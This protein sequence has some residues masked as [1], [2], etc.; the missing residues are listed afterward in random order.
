MADWQDIPDNNLSTIDL[1]LNAEGASGRF[2]DLV[3]SVYQQESGSG[4]NSRTSNAG[5]VGGMQIKPDTF[6]SVADD[7]WDINHPVDNARAG[8]R[9][10]KTMWDKSGGNPQLA[11]AGYYGG[12]GGLDKARRGVAVSDP[13]NPNAPTTLEYGDQVAARM[14][15][16]LSSLADVPAKGKSQ[17][18]W[19][20]IP[21]EDI[22]ETPKKGMANILPSKEDVQ[23]QADYLRGIG[24]TGGQMLSGFLGMIPGGLAGIGSLIA[25]KTPGEAADVTKK[26]QDF[27]TYQPRTQ[28]G[29]E[30]SQRVSDLFEKALNTGTPIAAEALRAIPGL[31]TQLFPRTPQGNAAAETA[32]R[33]GLEAVANIL[34]LH[35]AVKAM[36][37]PKNVASPIADS[38]SKISEGQW[39]DVEAP[40][41]PAEPVDLGPG[42]GT[43]DVGQGAL[44]GAQNP[45]DVA[46]HVSALEQGRPT[47]IDTVQGDLFGGKEI[48]PSDIADQLHEQ[49]NIEKNVREGTEFNE[50]AQQADLFNRPA[51]DVSGVHSTPMRDVATD[52]PLTKSEYLARLDE[53]SKDPTT[54]FVKPEDMD[55]AYQKYVDDFHGVQGNLFNR[56]TTAAEFADTARAE[57]AQRIATDHPIVQRLA[58]T[59]REKQE[60]VDWLQQNST[61]LK[62]LY[63]ATDELTKAQNKQAEVQANLER[64]VKARSPRLRRQGGSIDTNLAT[65]GLGKLLEKWR[66]KRAETEVGENQRAPLKNIPGVADRIKDFLPEQRSMDDIRAEA[67]QSPDVN[68]NFLQRAANQLTAGGLYQSL[69]TGNIVIKKTFEAV[70]N[71]VDIAN[72][73]IRTVIQDSKN[74]LAPAL[75]DLSSKEIGELHAKMLEVEGKR[76]LS[77]DDLRADGF[78]EKQVKAYEAYRR[79]SDAAFDAINRARAAAGKEPID[80]RLGHVAGVF[81]GDFRAPV[82]QIIDGQK[83]LKMMIGNN[84]KWGLDRI[85]AK[86]AEAHPEWEVGQGEYVGGRSKG[87]MDKQSD[88]EKALDFLS[89]QDG[90]TKQLVQLYHDVMSR[91]AYNYL[92][93]KKHT[94]GKKGIEGAEGIKLWKTIEQNGI[95]GFKAQIKYVENTLKWA[96]FARVS[97]ELAPMLSDP[98]I[99][100]PNAKSWSQNYLDRAIGVANSD[101][102][103][104]LNSMMDG[105]AKATGVG[106]SAIRGVAGAT[107]NVASKLLLGFG[108]VGFLVTNMIQPVLGLPAMQQLLASRGL[109]GTYTGGLSAAKSMMDFALGKETKGFDKDMF[110]YASDH[111]ILSN[112]IFDHTT[113][114][115]RNTPYYINKVAEFGIGSIEEATRGV[116]FVALSKMLENAGLTKEQGLFEAAHKMTNIV[117]TDYRHIEMP[118]VFQDLGPVGHLAANLARYK[119]NQ[120]SAMSFYAR[121]IQ[122]NGSLRPFGAALGTMVASAGILGLLGFN[123]MDQ[124]Y[125]YFTSKMDKP[126]TLS[127]VV[128]DNVKNPIFSHGLVSAMT[129][130]DFSQRLGVQDVVPN[131]IGEAAFPGGSRLVDLAKA[132]AKVATGGSSMDVKRLAR[133]AAPNSVRGLIDRKFFEDK[134]GMAVSP[135]TLEGLYK[136]N[137]FDQAVKSIGMSSVKESKEK[138]RVWQERV[139]DQAYADK[140]KDALRN[141]LDDMY[142]KNTINQ[143]AVKKY[144]D[145]EGD[146]SLLAGAITKWKQGS[147]LSELQRRQLTTAAGNTVN[148]AK[149]AQRLGRIEQ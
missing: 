90:A 81:S 78:S 16:D 42:A 96:E 70:S 77:S 114:L 83:V 11:A 24:E 143:D 142:D 64:A 54:S 128:L 57:A 103:N 65:M 17:P 85:A 46:G 47:T 139:V 59:V 72:K 82:F 136:R 45:Y 8:I 106:P 6:N 133:E 12:E 66:N 131:S 109:K 55:A 105:I 35:G 108:N 39:Q 43:A 74:G 84:T 112:E 34:P 75:R 97:K 124:L 110:Q 41:K 69:K 92:N 95:E 36:T 119:Q 127:R 9:Y 1:A 123:E 25:G 120:L 5:A 86:V 102:A 71:A 67:R 140:R 15:R 51:D 28:E 130:I 48:K 10:L 40:A 61:D 68:E 129:G 23:K 2:A 32:G 121:E 7:G 148:S 52:K 30:A 80:R 116:T 13:R 104:G 3:R 126:D 145:A 111:G 115:R 14:P 93:Q 107:K 149:R 31:G 4:K 21:W 37:E 98:S 94:L 60:Q 144:M 125:T 117:M 56:P 49:Y 118:K 100:M 101:W 135:S 18:K 91:D 29:K 33:A 20:D 38:L 113:Q 50:N 146:P 88:F 134:N 79:A 19:E 26:V 27:L 44:F 76:T 53:L 89:Q 132:G 22:P 138:A 137:D 63:D 99:N 73:N 62:A 87:V 147:M 122:N 58:D 141:I